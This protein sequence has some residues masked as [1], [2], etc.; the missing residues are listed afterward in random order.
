MLSG[1]AQTLTLL[2]YEPKRCA[3]LTHPGHERNAVYACEGEVIKLYGA[4]AIGTPE[5]RAQAE[6]HYTALALERGVA[7]P[8]VQRIGCVNGVSYTVSQRLPGASLSPQEE[9]SPELWRDIGRWLGAFH[10]PTLQSGT[11]WMERWVQTGLRNLENLQSGLKDD[12]EARVMRDAKAWLLARADTSLFT[13]L[14]MGTCHNDFAPHNLLCQ[15]GRLVGVID[16]E[17]ASEG[18]TELDLAR[19]YLDVFFRYPASAG[20]FWEGYQQKTFTTPGFRARLPLY[21]LGVI[22][23]IAPERLIQYLGQLIN[24][25]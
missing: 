15:A 17:L 18:N 23:V 24:L 22:P 19:L 13:L 20:F 7:A 6:K 14:P 4:G 1:D 16:F 25:R 12:N 3:R 10:A 8:Q 21:L 9:T 5:S 11:L 2:G